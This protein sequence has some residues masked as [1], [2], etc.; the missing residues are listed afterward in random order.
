[1]TTERFHK[2]VHA[3]IRIEELLTAQVQFAVHHDGTDFVVSYRAE[4]NAPTAGE[5]A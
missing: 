5:P 3:L 4:T 1:M 2:R